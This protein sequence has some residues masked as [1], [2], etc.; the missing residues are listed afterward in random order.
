MKLVIYYMSKDDLKKFK[1]KKGEIFNSCPDI[2]SIKNLLGE[3]LELLPAEIVLEINHRLERIRKINESLRNA[4]SECVTSEMP[5]NISAVIKTL[6][7][8]FSQDK[9]VVKYIDEI[10]KTYL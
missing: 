3:H 9:D 4:I 10:V 1:N 7:I 2:D 5:Y 6:K 8:K